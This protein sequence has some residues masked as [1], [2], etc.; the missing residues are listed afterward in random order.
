VFTAAAAES[1]AARGETVV[2]ARVETSPED[3]K[4]MQAAAGILTARGGMTSHAALVGRQMGKVCV[5]GAAALEIDPRRKKLCAGSRTL[6]EGDWV[7]IDGTSGE[8]I[9]GRVATQPSLIM[10]VLAGTKS[11][12]RD[13]GALWRAYEQLMRWADEI[14]RLRVRANADQPDQCRAARLLGAEGIG[15]CR[16]EH[17]FFGAKKIDCVRAMILAGTPEERASALKRLL[18]LQRAD[19]EGIFEEMK[20]FPVTIR[21]LD[22][23][24][25]EFL[26]HTREEQKALAAQLG[27][28]L[29]RVRARVDSLAEQNPMLGHRGCRLGISHPEITAMQARAIF[30]AGLAVRARTHRAPQ[31]EVMIPLVGTLREFELQAEVV[32]ATA[33]EVFR[34][35]GAKIPFLVGTMIELPRAALAASQIARGAE[36]FSFGTN[37]LTQTTLGVSRDDAGF[38]PLYVEREIWD[39]DPFQSI[40]VDGVGRLMHLAC[41]EGRAARTSLKLGICGEHGGDPRS[42]QFCEKLCLDY[43]SCSPLRLPVARLAAAQA[44]L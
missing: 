2:L 34:E 4:G 24:L 3:I 27:I 23:P 22:P 5:V 37:D 17:M 26:P 1:F 36:F 31:I 43:V 44:A 29:A 42:I 32:R 7:S 39:R 25:H 40:D 16:T 35:Q 14:R 28:S 41:S 9:E 15:L 21:T 30:E 19:F 8:V 18:P 13:G 33:A 6:R 10:A 12:K 11:A 20:G 38:I